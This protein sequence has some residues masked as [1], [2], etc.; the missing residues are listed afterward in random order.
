MTWA[1][2]T[3]EY[4]FIIVS[5]LSGTGAAAVLLY[6]IAR[7]KQL[8]ASHAYPTLPLQPH[9]ELASRQ[10]QP[11][12]LDR[13]TLLNRNL[14][15]CPRCLMIDHANA[16]FCTR[17]GMPMQLPIGVPRSSMPSI[18]TRYLQ[19]GPNRL[20]GVS[21]KV[22]PKTRVGVIVGIQN[23]DNPERINESHNW[24]SRYTDPNAAQTKRR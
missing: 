15:Q 2:L 20:F 14:T 24:T 13:I 9:S 21:M 5:V 7:S 8:N 19:D 16:R 12:A 22:G 23:Q 18:E 3:I 6:S 10:Q 11:S 4:I 1:Q 17:C